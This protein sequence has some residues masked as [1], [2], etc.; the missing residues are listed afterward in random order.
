MEVKGIKERKIIN[1]GIFYSYQIK[2][3]IKIFNS[4]KQKSITAN[5]IDF[6]KQTALFNKKIFLLVIVSTK[7]APHLLHS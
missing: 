6:K 1:Y 7:D 5:E 4:I 3:M 2:S